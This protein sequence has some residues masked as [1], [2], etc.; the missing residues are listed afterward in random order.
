M[1]IGRYSS[2]LYKYS[3]RTGGVSVEANFCGLSGVDGLG[4]CSGALG[5]NLVSGGIAQNFL[6]NGVRLVRRFST[7]GQQAAFSKDLYKILGVTKSTDK[8]GIKTAY[9]KLVKQHHPDLNKD[10]GSD[11]MIKDINLAYMVLSNEEKKKE[12]DDYLSQKD[13]ISDFESK[14]QRSG[15][16]YARYGPVCSA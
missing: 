10:K 6:A 8:A 5:L 14:A 2:T 7:L 16:Q 15:G 3:R 4:V 11:Q 12:Y 9:T 1:R 13:K